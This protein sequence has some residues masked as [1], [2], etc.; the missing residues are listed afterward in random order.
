MSKQHSK[1]H[2]NYHIYTVKDAKE[3]FKNRDIYIWGAGQKG[4]GFLKALQ[5]N[6]FNVKAFLDSS[7]LLI[8]TTYENIP[9]LNPIDVLENK[10]LLNNAYILTA[11]VDKKNKEMF[12]ICESY[13]LKKGQDFINI[14]K[15]T[16]YYPVIEISGACNLKCI[17][18]P[19]GDS[20]N[21][22][23]KNGFMSIE[24]YKK[25]IK[26]LIK[27]MPFLYLV[28]LYIWG[29]PLL[30]PD[31][32]KIIKIN[33]EYGIASGISTNL[34]YEKHLE[35]VIKSKPPQIRVSVSGYGPEH[36][37]ITHTGGKWDVF[38]NNL[39][40][41]HDY[42]EKYKTNTIVEVYFH[43][44]K[45]NIAEYIKVKELCD[46]LGFRINLT[47]SRV[48]HDYALEYVE[49]GKLPENAKKGAELMLV[50]LDEML[51]DAK[52]EKEKDCLLKR[53]VPVIN[54]D[55][56]V[57]ACCDYI[58]R[59]LE[60]NYLET[61]FEEIIKLREEHTLCKTCQKYALHRYSNPLYY[62]KFVEKKI[63]TYTKLSKDENNA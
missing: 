44:N 54:W 39:L 34:N 55:L 25:V 2:V 30:N 18:C 14:Q 46:N 62:T 29:E 8:G 35:K 56:S 9:I 51:E 28:D 10:K 45:V 16:P 11:S 40:K 48:F 4:R 59:K 57:M 31:L 50:S 12:K 13:D 5:R 19:R 43:V 47:I 36:Y 21:R 61:S 53:I 23:K 3:M 6:G 7:P 52:R 33:N 22:F 49:T 26:K 32:S 15:F 38:Y 17:S 37:E 42:I 1:V 20:R 58:Y 27:E 63:K 41:L 24:N 60:D